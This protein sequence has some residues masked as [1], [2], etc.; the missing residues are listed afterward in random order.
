MSN[1]VDIR[2]HR[3]TPATVLRFPGIRRFV[4]SFASPA[5]AA[6][7]SAQPALYLRHWAEAT[8]EKHGIETTIELLRFALQNAE[9]RQAG[10]SS[11]AS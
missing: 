9:A 6:A 3:A 4:Q 1:V 8:T 11:D 10:G 2:T 7:E 5:R